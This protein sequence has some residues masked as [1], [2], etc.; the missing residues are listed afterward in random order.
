MVPT[1]AKVH[2]LLK[3]RALAAAH[4]DVRDDVVAHSADDGKQD[5]L[6][7]LVATDARQVEGRYRRVRLKVWLGIYGLKYWRR[8]TVTRVDATLAYV[9]KRPATNAF[10]SEYSASAAIEFH[11][12]V[13]NQ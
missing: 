6:N 8:P 7:R 13:K 9:S 11:S 3:A 12:F 1:E 2:A 10:T 5:Q 4:F